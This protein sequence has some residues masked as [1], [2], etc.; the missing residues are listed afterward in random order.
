MVEWLSPGGHGKAPRA[1]DEGPER[2]HPASGAQAS[3][4]SSTWSK[5]M[6]P[7]R[8][9]ICPSVKRAHTARTRR[10]A[11]RR[12]DSREARTRYLAQ[13]RFQK[14][15]LWGGSTPHPAVGY[16]GPDEASFCLSTR[17]VSTHLLVS[18]LDL[19]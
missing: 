14:A 13:R 16:E 3:T 2:G 9:S 19:L 4:G 5:F 6:S 12:H 1:A 8:A 10:V 7:R 17:L 11:V 18:R 15:R